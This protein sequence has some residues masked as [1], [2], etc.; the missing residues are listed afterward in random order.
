MG[1]VTAQAFNMKN[2]DPKIIEQSMPPPRHTMPISQTTHGVN[3][4]MDVTDKEKK[5]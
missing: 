1:I 5:P 4:L 2:N 3:N